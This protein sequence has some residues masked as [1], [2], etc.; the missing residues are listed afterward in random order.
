MYIHLVGEG[1]QALNNKHGL[2]SPACG[3]V[4]KMNYILKECTSKYS[5]RHVQSLADNAM[6]Q[7]LLGEVPSRKY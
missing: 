4:G 6:S 2:Y 5:S 1:V 3:V 7:G